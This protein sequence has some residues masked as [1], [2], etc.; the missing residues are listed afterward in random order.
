MNK[1]IEQKA[2]IEALVDQRHK[3]A[4]TFT[5]EFMGVQGAA[6]DRATMDATRAI[7]ALVPA[8]FTR[9]DVEKV[10]VR[11]WHHEAERAAP[12]V[13]KLCTVETFR[14]LSDADRT[15]WINRAKAALSAIGDMD[16]G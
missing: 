12:N 6:Y 2:A 5:P 9:E 16:H 8:R 1:M 14:E 10:A 11:L 13:A 15:I 3:A 4:G 7:N